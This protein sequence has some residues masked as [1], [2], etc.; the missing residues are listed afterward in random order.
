LPSN[1]PSV[2]LAEIVA[3]RTGIPAG[4]LRAVMTRCEKILASNEHPE[5]RE[6]VRL[7]SK[8][9]DIEHRLAI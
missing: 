6:L 2:Q 9:R 4:E 3:N 7:V 5:D 8:I 1:T